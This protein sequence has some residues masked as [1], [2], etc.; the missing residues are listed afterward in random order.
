MYDQLADPSS[1]SIKQDVIYDD[2]E[3]ARDIPAF[4]EFHCLDVDEILDPIDSFSE[5]LSCR[6][7]VLV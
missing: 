5:Y 2:P 4:I 6:L 1:A 3:S 7:S